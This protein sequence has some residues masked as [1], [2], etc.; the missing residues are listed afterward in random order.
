MKL[1]TIADY[2]AECA[3]VEAIIAKSSRRAKGGWIKYL[4]RLWKEMQEY[5]KN[6]EQTQ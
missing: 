3:R 4:H 5:K 2:E 6:K 1:Q